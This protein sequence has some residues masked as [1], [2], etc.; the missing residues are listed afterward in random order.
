MSYV[1]GW[2]EGLRGQESAADVA[3]RGFACEHRAHAATRLRL[4]GV[5]GGEAREQRL[6]GGVAQRRHGQRLQVQQLR[7][8]RELG[9]QDEVPGGVAGEDRE[10]WAEGGRWACGAP[11]WINHGLTGGP[12]G[13][14]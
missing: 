6:E 3:C 10:E 9:G 7:G 11:L 13:G 5:E 14:P 4:D 8:G 1:R 2:G 12:Q